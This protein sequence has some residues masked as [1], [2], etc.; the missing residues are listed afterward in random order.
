MSHECQLRCCKLNA[1]LA[2]WFLGLMCACAEPWTCAVVRVSLSRLF[3]PT[4]LLGGGLFCDEPSFS[5]M[6]SRS[7]ASCGRLAVFPSSDHSYKNLR[8]DRHALGWTFNPDSPPLWFQICLGSCAFWECR[9]NC[10][11]PS[12]SSLVTSTHSTSVYWASHLLALLLYCPCSRAHAQVCQFLFCTW[13]LLWPASARQLLWMPCSLYGL[14]AN[15][16]R[17][18]LSWFTVSTFTLIIMIASSSNL[19]Y[20]WPFSRQFNPLSTTCKKNESEKRV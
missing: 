6:L 3:P 12:P 18:S 11:I 8:L 7:V 4:Y 15:W 16:R 2:V 5:A 20:S 9:Y 1:A 13:V 17:S 19:V 10:C 14:R